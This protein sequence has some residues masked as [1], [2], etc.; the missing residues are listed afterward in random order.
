MLLK[1]K[2]IYFWWIFV[3]CFKSY[4]ALEEIGLCALMH[5]SKVGFPDPLLPVNAMIDLG[6]S[7]KDFKKSIHIESVR[8]FFKGFS[9]V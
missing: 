6:K 7:M 8:S 4:I 2:P 9:I 1:I 3:S 5:F